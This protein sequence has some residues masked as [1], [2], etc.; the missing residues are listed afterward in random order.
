MAKFSR[1]PDEVK[2]EIKIKNDIVDVV[3]QYV[4]LTKKTGSN[5]FGLCPFHGENT[6]SFSVSP[7]KQIYHCFGC[8]KGGDVI[9]FVQS[10]EKITYVDALKLLADRAGI[11][12]PEISDPEQNRRDHLRKRIIEM[13]TEAARHFYRHLTGPEGRGAVDYLQRRGISGATAQRFGMG[14]AIDS[15]Q[16]LY[17][18]LRSKGFSAEELASSGLFQQ[19]RRGGWYDIFRNRLIFPII[20]TM[21]RIVAFGGRVMDDSQPKYLNSPETPVY[22]KGQ[23]LYAMNLAKKT[24]EDSFVIVEGYMDVIALHQAGIDNAVGVLG[25]ALT[26]RQCKQI[27][28]YT[29]KVIVGFD[30]DNAGQNAADRSFAILERSDFNIRVLTI[31]DGKDPDEYIRKNGVDRF[32]ALLKQSMDVWEFRFHRLK[33]RN[34]VDGRLD[35]TGFLDDACELLLTI[36]RPVQFDLH[37]G[38]V[39]KILG[40][41]RVDS[42]R[43]EVER[44]R[45]GG[46]RHRSRNRAPVVGPG[47]GPAG[48]RGGVAA[49][50]QGMGTS[51]GP[52]GVQGQ[53]GNGPMARSP[54]PFAPR[55]TVLTKLELNFLLLLS[56]RKDLY[57]TMKVPLTYTEFQDP[58][59]EGFP[60]MVL[61][62]AQT[63]QLDQQR[64][65]DI[66]ARYVLGGAP[67]VDL[68]SGA[69]IELPDHS[70]FEEQSRDTQRLARAIRL[71]YLQK[72]RDVLNQRL[73]NREGSEEQRKEWERERNQVAEQIIQL[74]RRK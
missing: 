12:L 68:L 31:P 7:Q 70:S 3:E 30:A 40:N 22:T 60:A 17:D 35:E 11:R 52:S 39:A 16:D 29:N 57:E 33:L 41:V 71:D 47:I 1:I 50:S 13:N 72:R 42:V 18:H 56:L 62:S 74:R 38:Q 69:M 10:I 54:D 4:T 26:E 46:G 27:R 19:N 64:L 9:N 36:D 34:T 20:D 25:T 43:Q 6:P 32:R 59:P 58:S 23:T 73:D 45:R 51:G 67:L 66:A 53:S 24:K 21:G 2:D 5:Y 15:W 63:K 14:F 28:N 61:R 55:P 49:T 8:G 44:L 48:P 65:M 37:V